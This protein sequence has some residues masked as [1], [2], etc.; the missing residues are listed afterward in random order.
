MTTAGWQAPPTVAD[1]VPGVVL[2]AA[3][4]TWVA[5][6]MT[7]GLVAFL[8]LALM[9]LAGSISDAFPGWGD[10]RW[11]MGVSTAVVVVLSAAADVAAFFLLRR[12]R[13]AAW[14]LLALAVVATLGGLAFVS[15][16]APLAV[17]AAG[18]AVIVLLLQP[19]ARRWVRPAPGAPQG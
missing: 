9:A 10:P 3:I 14:V 4:V 17:T 13:V 19:A 12:S 8:S 18:I 11:S 16:I 2:A 7:A 5:A 1:R 15:F 6:T